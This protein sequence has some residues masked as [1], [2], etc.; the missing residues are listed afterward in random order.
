VAGV[1]A[2]RA[3]IPER[4]WWATCFPLRHL[5]P[6]ISVTW[7]LL[8]VHFPHSV[9]ILPDYSVPVSIT[10]G[11]GFPITWRALKYYR[12]IALFV[13]RFLGGGYSALL[14]RAIYRD[15]CAALGHH[16]GGGMTLLAVI[17]VIRSNLYERRGG[18]G[19]WA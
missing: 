4:T 18:G 19:S 10:A 13:S 5:P 17:V 6:A 15:A 1:V 12:G 3:G 14:L 9:N 2:F 8:P 11:G 16:A 7:F